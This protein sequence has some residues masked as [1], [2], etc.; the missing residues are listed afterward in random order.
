MKQKG[1][2]MVE[3]L[4]AIAILALLIVMA[5]PTMRAIQAR[6]EK[7]KYEEYG[8]SMLSAAKLYTDS[9]AEDLFPKGLK[10]EHAK[11]ST[12]ELAKKDL[13]KNIGFT[14]VS[15]I[16]PDSYVVVTKFGDDYGFCLALK[17][18]SKGSNTVVYEERNQEGYCKSYSIKKVI[19]TYNTPAGEKKFEDEIIKGEESYIILSPNSMGMDFDS[20]R[21]HFNNWID[22][23]N[24]HAYNPGE[25]YEGSINSDVV[26]KSST[27]KWKYNIF[28]HKGLADSGTM[29]EE[30]LVCYYGANCSL[31]PNGYSKV[32]HDFDKWKDSSNNGYD[33]KENVKTK[34]GDNIDHDGYR[35]D[36]TATFTPKTYKLTY[37]SGSGCNPSTKNGTYGKEWGDLCNPKKSGY[38]FK[39]WNTSPD[40]T[41][42]TIDK[43]SKVTGDITVYDQWQSDDI[44]ITVTFKPNGGTGKDIVRTCTYAVNATNKSCKIESPDIERKGWTA[45]GWNTSSSAKTSDWNKKTEKTVSADAIYY[46]ITFKEL[47][48][49]F[50]YKV[51]DYQN[52]NVLQNASRNTSE[53]CKIYNTETSCTVTT[54]G[55]SFGKSWNKT[56]KQFDLNKYFNCKWGAVTPGEKMSIS[57]DETITVSVTADL[58]SHSR[59]RSLA[60]PDQSNVSIRN[61]RTKLYT[62]GI[63]KKTYYG[64]IR[65]YHYFVWDGDWIVDSKKNIL[66]LHGT[67]EANETICVTVSDDKH[68]G[69]TRRGKATG[70]YSAR[71]SILF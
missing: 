61:D 32:G 35:V 58:K 14:D 10:N 16:S 66:W 20:N 42:T 27:R 70:W 33:D 25:T 3:L 63:N 28:F 48:A 7:R 12:D 67:S 62:Y 45:I 6:N 8:R 44:T 13:L 46:A 18:K 26:L 5:F 65:D 36:L 34:I 43:N 40:G 39:G 4:A 24:N 49:T 41:G 21:D 47:T 60:E 17:C 15:C 64:H 55:V 54:P 53:K 51:N 11:I 31:L 23:S 22:Q 71:L 59:I 57:K 52:I 38:T 37:S 50:N 19:Y 1:F 29:Q 68:C 2:T 56:G 30:P 9:Y 69:R